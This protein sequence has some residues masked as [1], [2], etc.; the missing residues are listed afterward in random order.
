MCGVA[1]YMSM[2]NMLVSAVLSRLRATIYRLH[3][4]ISKLNFVIFFSSIYH[5]SVE[6]FYAKIATA[7]NWDFQMGE[8]TNDMWIDWASIHFRRTNGRL[9]HFACPIL[10]PTIYKLNIIP[11]NLL[12]TFVMSSNSFSRIYY[13]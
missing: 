9:H 2:C 1:R 5:E 8:H 6:Y 12:G 4:I 7:S 13:Y 11:V 10:R 3:S